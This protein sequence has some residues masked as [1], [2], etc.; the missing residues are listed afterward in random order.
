MG[1]IDG[2][3]TEVQRADEGCHSDS[4]TERSSGTRRNGRS[5]SDSQQ[6][7]ADR[8]DRA[9]GNVLRFLTGGILAQLIQDYESQLGEAQSTIDKEQRRIEQLNKRLLNL[10]RLQESHQS[11]E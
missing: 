11:Q 10:R 3:E 6:I 4:A 2:K 8:T 5:P 9:R 1:Q 7:G